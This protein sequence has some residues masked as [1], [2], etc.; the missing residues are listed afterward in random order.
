MYSYGK[1]Q[2]YVQNI[3]LRHFCF[4]GLRAQLGTH[5][6]FTIRQYTHA[7]YMNTE[8]NIFLYM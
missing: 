2:S 3:S 8:E 7:L 1:E 5:K 6:R 4:L